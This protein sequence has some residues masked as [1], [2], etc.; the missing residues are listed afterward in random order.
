MH[1]AAVVER[2]LVGGAGAAM[3]TPFYLTLD[4]GV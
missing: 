3:A 1:V 4:T 2:L